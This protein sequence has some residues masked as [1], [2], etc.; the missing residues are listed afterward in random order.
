MQS[1]MVLVIIG[2]VTHDLVIIGD[3]ES[4]KIGGATYFQSFVFE[5]FYK[6]YLAIVNCSDVNLVNDFPSKDKVNVILKEDTHFFINYYPDKDDM[7][8]RE[9]LSNFANI[10]IYPNDLKDVLPDEIEGFVLNPLNK[11]DFPIGTIEYLK[12][13]NVPIFISVQGFL[14]SPGNEVNDNYE[15]ELGNFNKLNSILEGV[16]SIFLD[17]HEANMIGLDFDV[18][19]MIITN[20]SH[21][22][23]I[24][25]N[26]D[27]I[28]INA[29]KC[30]H[31]VDST[32]CG[33]TYM[34][35]YISKRLNNYS[36]RQSGEFASEIASK[37]L[38]KSGHY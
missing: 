38:T 5:K 28:K 7:D 23:R 20:G 22:S 32:G 18:D 15:I 31:I 6:D 8:Y 16:S 1:I 33:D 14:R 10:P 24:I 37:K 21:G 11:Y 34:A 29:V 27:E 4:E 19:E 3:E 9:Q 25:T 17:E 2:P 35:A 26:N 30:N 13:F 36:D 12:S